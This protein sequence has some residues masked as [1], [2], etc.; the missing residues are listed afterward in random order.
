[1][2]FYDEMAVVA[3]ELLGEFG[4]GVTIARTTSG[5]YDPATGGVTAPTA[6]QSG[7]AVVREYARQHVDGTLI[8]SG[9]KRVILAA[10]GLTFAPAPGDSVTAGGDVLQVVSV[11]ERNPAGTPLVYE[12]QG[13]R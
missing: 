10:S 6:S 9:D 1:M 8:Q 2:G 4:Q 5:G 3:L 12:L 7:S 11:I 13:R